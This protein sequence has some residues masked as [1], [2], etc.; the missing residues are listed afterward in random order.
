MFHRAKWVGQIQHDGRF[1]TII[2]QGADAAITPH[3]FR[4]AFAIGDMESGSFEEAD[5]A[6][7]GEQRLDVSMTGFQNERLNERAAPPAAFGPIMNGQRPHLGQY[8]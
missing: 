4:E 7:Q 2:D 3:L 8:R 1:V 5:G 6:S